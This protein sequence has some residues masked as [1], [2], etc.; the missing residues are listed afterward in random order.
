VH[1]DFR[2][3]QRLQLT[4]NGVTLW[5]TIG[6]MVNRAHVAQWRSKWAVELSWRTFTALGLDRN[7]RVEVRAP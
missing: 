3:G 4:A 7:N 1:P 2:P 5:C 6:D